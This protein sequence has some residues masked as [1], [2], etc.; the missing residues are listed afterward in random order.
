ME[1]LTKHYYLCCGALGYGSMLSGRELPTYRKTEGARSSFVF[2][3]VRLYVVITQKTTISSVIKISKSQ[4]CHSSKG[5]DSGFA[6]NGRCLTGNWGEKKRKTACLSSG[7]LLDTQKPLLP[8]RLEA[9]IFG[10]EVG[11]LATETQL[12]R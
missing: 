3:T 6:R 1:F 4:N 9:D 8:P 5:R 2:V 11:C 10:V 12:A 7:V